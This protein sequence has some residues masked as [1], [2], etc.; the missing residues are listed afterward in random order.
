MYETAELRWFLRG[1]VPDEAAAW[2]EAVVDVAC[3]EERTDRYLVPRG[4]GRGCKLREGRA[5]LKTRLGEA[6]HLD[7][8]AAAGTPTVWGKRRLREL[9]DRP[10][11]DVAKRRRFGRAET[12]SGACTLELATVEACGATWW[13]VCLEAVGQDADARERALREAAQRWLAHPD[14]PGLPAEAARAYPAWL[15]EVAG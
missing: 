14:T 13:S 6:A 9:P 1:P 10:T 3:V 2:F 11:V 8:G 7:C 4:D 12:S 5:E 15:R